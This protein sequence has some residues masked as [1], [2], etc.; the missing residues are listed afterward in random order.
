MRFPASADRS[1]R[2][3][4]LAFGIRLIFEGIEQT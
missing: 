4:V 3:L 1:P 2:R